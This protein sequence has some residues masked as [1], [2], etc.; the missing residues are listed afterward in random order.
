[1]RHNI[2][3]SMQSNI[4]SGKDNVFANFLQTSGLYDYMEIGKDN[5]EDLILLLDGKV[6][7]SIYCKKCKTERVFT[8]SPYIHFVDGTNECY[9]LKLSEEVSRIQKEYALEN[10]PSPGDLVSE[11]NVAWRWKNE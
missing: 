1:M 5:I 4:V 11:K 10:T 8:M 2:W 6:R 7:I 3:G 9:S